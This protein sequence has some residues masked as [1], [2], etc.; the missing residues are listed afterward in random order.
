[1]NL[2]NT[3]THTWFYNVKCTLKYELYQND[4]QTTL[5]CII[6]AFKFVFKRDFHVLLFSNE[7]KPLT[8]NK[9]IPL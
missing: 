3:H 6:I 5:Y 1:M 7:L 2:S 8:A 4:F 9:N